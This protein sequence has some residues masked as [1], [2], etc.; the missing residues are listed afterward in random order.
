MTRLAMMSQK[1]SLTKANTDEL[2]EKL[3]RRDALIFRDSAFYLSAASGFNVD[4]PICDR[5]YMR[6]AH[7]IKNSAV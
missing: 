2:K 7:Y 4:F 1:E 5:C 3:T 6:E